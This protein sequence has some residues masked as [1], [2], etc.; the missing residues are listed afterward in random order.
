MLRPTAVLFPLFKTCLR[1]QLF[2]AFN[3]ITV[4][5]KKNIYIYVKKKT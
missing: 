2:S 4:V 1:A 3:M 5:Q